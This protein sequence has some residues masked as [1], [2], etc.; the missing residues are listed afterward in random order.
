MKTSRVV[1][2]AITLLSLGGCADAPTTSTLP[3][4]GLSS[5]ASLASAA[6]QIDASGSF[7]AL[8]DFATLTLT[9]RGQNCLLTVSGQLVF[10]GTIQGT[11]TGQTSALVFASCADVATN[12]PGT[13]AD[14]FKFEGTFEGSVDGEAAQAN[15]SYMGQV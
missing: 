11:A 10:S 13:F 4:Q 12:P 3:T 14:V 8:V 15:L 9:P 6:R 2:T 5:A 1:A 7:D